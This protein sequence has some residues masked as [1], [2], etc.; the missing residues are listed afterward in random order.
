M[1]TDTESGERKE[2]DRKR[3][4]WRYR[5]YRL[6][7]IALYFALVLLVVNLFGSHFPDGDWSYAITIGLLVGVSLFVSDWIAAL[8][9]KRKF[10]P[11]F[12]GP[13]HY[14]EDHEK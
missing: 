1:E 13:L 11:R 2:I 5:A 6:F 4:K 12:W 14:R 8:M 9:F 7:T 10:R 3:A